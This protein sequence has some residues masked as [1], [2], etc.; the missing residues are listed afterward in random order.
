MISTAFVYSNKK[1]PDNP[2]Y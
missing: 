1:K 2:D